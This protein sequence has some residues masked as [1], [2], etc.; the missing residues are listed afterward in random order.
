MKKQVMI[1]I[2][3]LAALG[4]AGCGE[5]TPEAEEIRE[6]LAEEETKPVWYGTWE[7]TEYQAAAV[8]AWPIAELEAQVGN[9][10]SYEEAA[11]T[12]GDQKMAIEGYETMEDVYTIEAIAEDYG[13]DLSGWADG[14]EAISF[15]EAICPEEQVF[16][17]DTLFVTKTGDVWLYQEGAFFRTK[18]VKETE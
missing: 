2:A 11:V 8:S 3:V 5:K 4:M 15:A 1:G 17:G 9:K 16:L 7:I 13:A 6:E 18:S 10:V 12:V 14:T